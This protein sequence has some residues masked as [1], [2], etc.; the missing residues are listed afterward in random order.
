MLFLFYFLRQNN[1]SPT[2]SLTGAGVT[3]SGNVPEPTTPRPTDPLPVNKSNSCVYG[4]TSEPVNG[5]KNSSS[6]VSLMCLS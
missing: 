4:P 6:K 1:P 3:K 5:I 2:K